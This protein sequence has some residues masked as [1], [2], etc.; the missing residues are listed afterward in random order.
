MSLDTA[1]SKALEAQ[2]QYINEAM[3]AGEKFKEENQQLIDSYGV[4]E[5]SPKV[6]LSSIKPEGA[7]A[8]LSTLGAVALVITSLTF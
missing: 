7:S 4:D 1:Q 8:M 2:N 5:Y 6:N 3:S